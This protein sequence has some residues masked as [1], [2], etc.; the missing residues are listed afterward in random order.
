MYCKKCGSD[1]HWDTDCLRLSPETGKALMD[2][3]VK[4]RKHDK[5]SED[6]Q[7]G[8]CPKCG[9]TPEIFSAAKKWVEQRD[10]RKRYMREYR[11][12]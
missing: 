5:K 10:K 2:A 7:S 3:Y 1:K 9:S 6:A 11:K 12:R 8:S 4:S